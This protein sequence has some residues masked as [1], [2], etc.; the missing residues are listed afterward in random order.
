[1]SITWE[2]VRSF[3]S[4]NTYQRQGLVAKTHIQVGAN[5]RKNFRLSRPFPQNLIPMLLLPRTGCEEPKCTIMGMAV[6]RAYSNTY[7]STSQNKNTEETPRRVS[8][9][10]RWRVADVRRLLQAATTPNTTHHSDNNDNSNST[11]S[12]NNDSHNKTPIPT[13]NS[14][15]PTCTTMTTT[16]T[17]TTT[18]PRE[19]PTTQGPASTSPNSNISD[20]A[21]TSTHLG[22][23]KVRVHGLHHLLEGGRVARRR[24]VHHERHLLVVLRGK[25]CCCLGSGGKA[26]VEKRGGSITINSKPTKPHHHHHHHH[27]PRQ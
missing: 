23:R 9:K 18:I 22:V 16:I 11:T 14:P 10:H 13:A 15:P 2:N 1:M 3:L 19:K 17:T 5:G 12:N 8:T 6:T 21:T 7:H 26:N 4:D 27:Q 24:G 25:R 20:N